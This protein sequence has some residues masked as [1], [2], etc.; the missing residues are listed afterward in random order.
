[1]AISSADQGRIAP[2]RLL[3]VT[4]L[5][6]IAVTIAN[7]IVYAIATALFAGPSQFSY[8]SPLSIA[9]S[10]TIY[11][12]VAAIVY[13]VI[14]RYAKRPTRTFRIVAVVA[15]L[16]SFMGPFSARQLEP[17]AD[18]TTV[19]VL[20]LMHVVAAAIT[21]GMFTTLAPAAGPAQR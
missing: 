6:I 4:P 5:A 13:A 20:M 21:V 10:I 15:L 7:M 1:M 2:W 18:T 17:P 14:R 3:W 19:V 8:L 9:A 16:L 11:L 12:I